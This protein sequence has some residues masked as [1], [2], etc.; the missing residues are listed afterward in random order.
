MAILPIRNRNRARTHAADELDDAAHVIRGIRRSPCRAARDSRAR[1]RRAPCPPPPL[2]SRARRGCRC[3]TFRRASDRTARPS[4]RAQRAW[5]ACRPGRFPDRRDADRT[6]ADRARSFADPRKRE[7]L[8]ALVG[9]P[10]IVAKDDARR[11]ERQPKAA[12]AAGER[13]VVMRIVSVRPVVRNAVNRARVTRRPRS[14]PA[15]APKSP[16]A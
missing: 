15:S 7:R 8:V 9:R 2:P 11:G 4:V 14:I 1:R 6:P 3:S 5:R 12:G 10:V 13:K 16:D